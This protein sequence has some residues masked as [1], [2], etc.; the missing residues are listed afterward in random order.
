M[1]PKKKVTTRNPF[2]IKPAIPDRFFCDRREDTRKIISLIE[3]GNN[4]VLMADRRIGKSSLLYHILH[5]DEIRSQYNTL[6]VDINGTTTSEEFINAMKNAISNPLYSTFPTDFSNRFNKITKEYSGKLKFEQGPI[7]LSTEFKKQ[8]ALQD[9]SAIEEIFKLFQNTKK[10][11]LITFDEFQQIERYDE[12]IT[13]LLRSKIEMLANT[14]F[15][16]AGS[17]KHLLASM[18]ISYNQPFYNSS[19]IYGLKK[20][21]IKTYASFCEEMFGLGDRDMEPE[22]A[23]TVYNLFFGTTQ[24]MQQVMN[25]AYDMTERNEKIDEAVIK[26]A[27]EDI[28]YD[29]SISYETLL[30]SLKLKPGHKNLLYAIGVEGIANN[31]TSQ[32]M[33]AKYNLGAPSTVYK[34]LQALSTGDNNII[35]EIA[36]D[37]YILTDRFFELWIAQ[38]AGLF[39]IKLKTAKTLFQKFQEIEKENSIRIKGNLKPTKP[40]F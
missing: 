21:P 36:K 32:A 16:Y 26:E 20:I 33:I 22:I 25:R 12:K 4:V 10:P 24:M 13:A 18:F 7:S 23:E 34:R 8:Q 30:S 38:Q 17:S 19:Q 5:C 31:L 9:K 15:I 14:N 29:R 6:Y 28:I 40:Q 37:N 11:N 35:T 3:S 1:S 39:D 2:F 27:I